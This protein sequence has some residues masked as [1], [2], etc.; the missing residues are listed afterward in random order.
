VKIALTRSSSSSAVICRHQPLS[1][2]TPTPLPA[3]TPAVRRA[4]P[5]SH[6]RAGAGGRGRA[7]VDSW[8]KPEMSICTTDTCQGASG[9]W[10][11]AHGRGWYVQ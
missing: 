1:A 7:C 11:H 10:S 4:C 8:V 9:V 2:V 3:V 6:W 5:R